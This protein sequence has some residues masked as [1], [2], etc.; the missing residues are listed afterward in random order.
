MPS[1]CSMLGDGYIYMSMQA[2]SSARDAQI[3]SAFE[4]IGYAFFA[5]QVQQNI[6]VLAKVSSLISIG[7]PAAS[8]LSP[9]N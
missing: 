9:N 4:S 8:D 1:V 5:H 7:S 3:R 6:V 2:V